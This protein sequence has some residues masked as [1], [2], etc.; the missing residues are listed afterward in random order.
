MTTILVQAQEEEAVVPDS[1]P[2]ELAKKIFVYNASKQFSDPI[3]QRM[4]LYDL[5]AENPNNYSLRD[6][7]ALLYLQQQQ[8]ASA[9]LVAQEVAQVVPDDGSVLLKK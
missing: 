9:A 1:I 5:L 3:I 7:L 4:A 2:V 6:S 8:F